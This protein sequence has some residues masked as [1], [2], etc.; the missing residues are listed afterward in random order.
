MTPEVRPARPLD[1]AAL[2]A[3]R[4]EAGWGA[5]EVPDWY[6]AMRLGERKMWVAEV[7]GKVVA[8]VALDFVDDDPEVADG[9]ATAALASLI[10]TARVARR[11]LGRRLSLF[12]E[13]QALARGVEVLTLNTRPS[14]AAALALYEDLG[15]RTFKRGPRSWGDAVFLRKRLE[16]VR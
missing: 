4:L 14:N 1:A 13:H 10:V 6:E 9:K 2:L 8:M 15:Y 11:G 5:D 12:A 3:L 7:D 16:A